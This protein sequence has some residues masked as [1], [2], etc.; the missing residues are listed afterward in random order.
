MRR[1][2]AAIEYLLMI[3]VALTMVLIVIRFIRQAAEQAGKTI[4]DT[5]KTISEYLNEGVSNA[6]EG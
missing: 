3:A 5:A 1:G 2:Q 4:N 6:G